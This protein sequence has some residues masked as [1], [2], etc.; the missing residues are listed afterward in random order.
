M[1]DYSG[2]LGA[3]GKVLGQDLLLDFGKFKFSLN[4]FA[5]ICEGRFTVE[6]RGDQDGYYLS[7][8]HFAS[9]PKNSAAQGRKAYKTMRYMTRTYAD[10][11]R[12]Q[13]GA[14]KN[15]L[16]QE[17]YWEL[18]IRFEE[19]IQFLCDLSYRIEQ[20]PKAA[21]ACFLHA[22]KLIKELDTYIQK[23]T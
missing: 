18:R 21:L 8:K 5:A 16:S 1:I 13:Q 22:T 12:K 2:K 23:S 10:F 20:D 3:D 6:D 7:L 15:V 17:P 9:E 14:I 19:A 11:L 4:G